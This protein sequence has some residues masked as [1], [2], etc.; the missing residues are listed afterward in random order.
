[1]AKEYRKT[2]RLQTVLMLGVIPFMFVILIG[3][4]LF[5][6]AG[7]EVKEAVYSIPVAGAMI[8]PDNEVAREEL[9]ARIN[10]L[11]E[12][13]E[14]LKRETNLLAAAVEEKDSQ[15]E[16]LEVRNGEDEDT[17]AEEEIGTGGDL[18]NEQL[19]EAV[20]TLEGMTALKAAS[21]LEMLEPEQAAVYLGQMRASERSQIMGRMESEQAAVIIIL[22]G[23]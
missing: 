3:F 12:E 11:K 8:K 4:V 19:K 7:D 21:I 2:N 16:E 23:E 10:E 13:N 5:S 9:E 14:S 20:R 22:L 15:I 18:E 6:F 1:M 17:G